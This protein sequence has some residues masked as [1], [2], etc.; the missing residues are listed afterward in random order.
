MHGS[1]RAA[2][3]PAP[4]PVEVMAAPRHEPVTEAAAP[5]ADSAAPADGTADI[6]PRPLTD[7]VCMQ[8]RRDSA[9]LLPQSGEMACRRWGHR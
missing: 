2:V 6:R 4:E 8:I 1:P 9:T 7:L 3:P 5:L